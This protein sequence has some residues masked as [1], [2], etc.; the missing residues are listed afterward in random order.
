MCVAGGL[1]Q[2]A[3]GPTSPLKAQREHRH[4]EAWVLT[5]VPP[6]QPPLFPPF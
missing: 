1:F 2:V 5:A 6:G 4:E 3:P